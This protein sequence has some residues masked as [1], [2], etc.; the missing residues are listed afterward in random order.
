[1]TTNPRP[2]AIAQLD[3]DDYMC[4]NCNTPWKCN[5]PHIPPGYEDSR[6][7][8]STYKGAREIEAA[9]D[10][11]GEDYILRQLGFYELEV[12]GD[13]NEQMA[14]DLRY[15]AYLI[16]RLSTHRGAVE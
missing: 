16:H 1:M 3:D 15:A 7:A 12:H 6:E 13:G 8:G 10:S 11:R 4:P 14:S 2:E 9:Q 5:G